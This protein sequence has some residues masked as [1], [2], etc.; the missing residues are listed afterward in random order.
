[1]WRVW[2]GKEQIGHGITNK[3]WDAMLAID[4]Y[5][6]EYEKV[7]F[8]VTDNTGAVVWPVHLAEGGAKGTP[9]P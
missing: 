6:Q 4:E 1:M 8:T 7:T 3:L 2:R 9:Q 5:R